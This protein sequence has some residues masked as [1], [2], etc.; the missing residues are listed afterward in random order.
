MVVFWVNV[1]LNVTAVLVVAFPE[2]TQPLLQNANDA[3]MRLRDSIMTIG[4]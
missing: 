4:L 1:A 2:I 3:L